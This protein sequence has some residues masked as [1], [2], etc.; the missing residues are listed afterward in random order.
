[1]PDDDI[2]LERREVFARDLGQAL[3]HTLMDWMAANGAKGVKP[4]EVIGGMALFGGAGLAWIA[5]AAD[6]PDSVTASWRTDYEALVRQTLEE[7]LAR[8]RRRGPG[9]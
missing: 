2:E 6:L 7:T 1:M 3:F 4:T 5:R 8:A 9:A